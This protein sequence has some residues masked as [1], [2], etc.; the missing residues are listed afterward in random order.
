MEGIDLKAE[1]RMDM[2]QEAREES[3]HEHRMFTDQEYAV[4]QFYNDIESAKEILDSVS[5]SLSDYGYE[6]SIQ[7]LLGEV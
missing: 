3:V 6:M 2:L 1:L 5:K 7:E 4:S